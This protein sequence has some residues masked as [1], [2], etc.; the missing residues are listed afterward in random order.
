MLKQNF[1]CFLLVQIKLFNKKTIIFLMR[2]LFLCLIVLKIR[3]QKRTDE[4]SLGTHTNYEKYNAISNISFKKCVGGGSVFYFTNIV[5][6]CVII[7]DFL[8]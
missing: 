5:C 3:S 6:T 8:F 1:T 7:S 2:F 4:F